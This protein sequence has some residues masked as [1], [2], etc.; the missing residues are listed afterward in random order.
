LRIEGDD[1]QAGLGAFGMAVVVKAGGAREA[2]LEGG[3]PRG[4][5]PFGQ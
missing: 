5:A 4:G 1:L 2:V 3:V